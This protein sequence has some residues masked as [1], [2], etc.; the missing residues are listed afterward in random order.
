VLAGK[1]FSLVLLFGSPE[2]KHEMKKFRF[3]FETLERV[4]RSRENDALR[5]LGEAQRRFQQERLRKENL[6]NELNRSLERREELGAVLRAPVEFQLETEYI[7]GTKQRIIQADQAILRA[8]RGVEKALRAYL[9]ARRATKALELLREKD[10]AAFRKALA[11]Q[12]QKDLDD[13]YVMRSRMN[14]ENVA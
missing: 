2:T 10:Y 11:K 1:T 6:V 7:S 8:S 13:L 3:R 5:V 14:K 9:T 12:E 4:R